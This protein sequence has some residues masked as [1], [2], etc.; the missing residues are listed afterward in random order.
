M[1]YFKVP[2]MTYQ[3]PAE[4]FIPKELKVVYTVPLQE[5]VVA[6][7]YPNISEL[8]LDKIATTLYGSGREN[9]WYKIANRNIRE[10][11]GWKADSSKIA[12]YMI[13]NPNAYV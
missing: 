3:R 11:I 7:K 6:K 10:I 13:P 2:E 1:R 5:F 12:E 4:N 8:Q 9:Q